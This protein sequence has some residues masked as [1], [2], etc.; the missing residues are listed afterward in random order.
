MLS[1]TFP[2][3]DTIPQNVRDI[4]D[5]WLDLQAD[6][7]SV[8]L[9][10]SPNYKNISYCKNA[11]Q[12]LQEHIKTHMQTLQAWLQ[13]NLKATRKEKWVRVGLE[14]GTAYVQGIISDYNHHRNPLPPDYTKSWGQFY[15]PQFYNPQFYNSELFNNYDIDIQNAITLAN[16]AVKRFDIKL[17]DDEEIL[18]IHRNKPCEGNAWYCD[19]CDIQELNWKRKLQQ[20]CKNTNNIFL[21]P[22]LQ[23]EFIPLWSAHIPEEEYAIWEPIKEYG[24]K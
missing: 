21:N 6:L 20:N 23:K 9:E 10:T 11:L 4:I 15:N 16:N 1:T 7:N 18:K 12:Q 5:K 2:I 22:V 3:A 8:R 13:E 19:L 14:R 17:C 24:Y